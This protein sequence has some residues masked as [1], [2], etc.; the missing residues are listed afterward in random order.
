VEAGL[1][2]A[3]LVVAAGEVGLPVLL[4]PSAGGGGKGMHLVRDADELDE[5][6]RAARREALG[7]FGDDDL[8]VERWI[9]RPRHI[10]IQVFADAHGNVVHLGERECSLQRRHQKVIEESPAP[11]FDPATRAAMGAHAVDVARNCSYQGAG[12]VEFIVPGDDPDTYFFLEMNTRLQVE[13]PVTELVTG[14][15]LVE[16]QLRVAAGE[17]LPF[18]QDDVV[19][20]GH[21]IEARVYAEDPDRDFLPTGGTVLVSHEPA[22][23]HVRTDSGIRAGT[24]VGTLY[25]PMLAKVIAWGPDRTIALRRLQRALAQTSI[26]GLG[27]NVAYLG[28]LL[29]ADDVVAGHLDT[30]LIDRLAAARPVLA[31]GSDLPVHVLVAAAL[32]E[33]IRAEPGAGHRSLGRWDE[34]DGWRV[35]EHA[36]T[37]TVW[38]FGV[39][40]TVTL[41]TR[42]PASASEVKVETPEG[43][44]LTGQVKATVSGSAL[45][46]T[47]EGEIRRYRWAEHGRTVWLGYEGRTWNLRREDTVG[48]A[49]RSRSESGS[50]G[51]VRSPMP[52]AVVALNVAVGDRVT[53]G[54]ALAIVEAMKM[55]HT[56]VSPVGG[57]T[58][59][60]TVQ[61][62]AQV[63]MD[64]PLITVTAD[65]A[66]DAGASGPDAGRSAAG[67]GSAPA[68]PEPTTKET[69]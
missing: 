39:D 53:A 65:A 31:P 67:P 29:A 46:I 9:D 57:V 64:Q 62:G 10:E 5:A 6:I 4:K 32:L 58:A 44:Y 40:R 33:A 38:E 35:G 42:G 1:S 66:D 52:G 34:A 24:E 3:E 36:W 25:D 11:D 8:L 15:D 28:E 47:E 17:V 13:H 41:S 51:I 2:D 61:V 27:T 26:L 23:P 50:G 20:T 59:E 37:T 56:L 30:G 49:G 68:T 18:G 12:T 22:L 16:L 48:S 55:E 60:V 63:V 69:P 43:E 21:A 45:E 7:A 19:V 14:L 54:Q